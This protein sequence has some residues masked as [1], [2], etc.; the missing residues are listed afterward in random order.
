MFFPSPN[1][2]LIQIMNSR[3]SPRSAEHL[4]KQIK[5]YDK[6]KDKDKKL[7]VR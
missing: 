7:T 3:L 6:D 5:K 2:N 1:L 4:E